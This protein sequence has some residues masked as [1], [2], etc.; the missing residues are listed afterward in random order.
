MCRTPVAEGRRKR[1]KGK[2][3]ST[4]QD[5]YEV[6]RDYYQILMAC[7]ERKADVLEKMLVLKQEQWE[8]EKKI[9]LERWEIEK[10]RL[11]RELNN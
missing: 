11:L 5:E 7:E 3:G 6:K 8:V 4:H 10:K 1:P 9:A 2:N